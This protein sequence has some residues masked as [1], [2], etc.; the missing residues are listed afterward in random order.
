MLS[1]CATA[2]LTCS[3]PLDC[4]LLAAAISA[5]MSLTLLT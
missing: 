3:M 2:A 5:T 4:S 1:I